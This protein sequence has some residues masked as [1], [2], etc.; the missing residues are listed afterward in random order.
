MKIF[1]ICFLIIEFMLILGCSETK[2][3]NEFMKKYGSTTRTYCDGSFLMEETFISP[4]ASS[5]RIRL[6]NSNKCEENITETDAP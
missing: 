2:E 6:I 3:Y 4:E 1:L 5:P